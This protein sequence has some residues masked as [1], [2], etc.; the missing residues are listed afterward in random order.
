MDSL[1]IY[2]NTLKDQNLKIEIEMNRRIAKGAKSFRFVQH[3]ELPS[4]TIYLG[5]NNYLALNQHPKI[6]QAIMDAYFTQDNTLSSPTLVNDPNH[7]QI[8]FEEKLAKF[9]GCESLAL[10]QSGWGAN[11]GLLKH[12][13]SLK[14]GP[15]Y[16]DRSA[17][18]SLY[19]GVISGK[20]ELARFKHNDMEDLERLIKKRGA[21]IIVV[22]AMYSTDG[23]LCPLAELV[24]IAEKYGCTTV[25]DEAHSFGAYGPNGE[26]YVAELGL[27]GKVDYITASFGK[28]FAARGG[29]VASRE[30]NITFFKYTAEPYMFSSKLLPH[31]IAQYEKTLEVI[32]EERWR[33]EK[34]HQHSSLI[35]QKL[36]DVGYALEKNDS[37]IIGLRLGNNVDEIIAFR[38]LLFSQGVFGSTFAYPATPI[39]AP[40]IRLAVRSDLTD[41]EINKIIN[42]SIYVYEEL[43]EA[44]LA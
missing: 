25:V 40:L 10:V 44:V 20:G 18:S 12:L 1:E 24:D 19:E 13:S 6:A 26:G 22:D 32:I 28:C 23:D 8:I 11:Y 30:K 4:H 14:T 9:L 41:A 34:L 37:H 2:E 27:S 15:I 35:R 7:P 5:S 36:A 21:G 3:D 17:H 29:L 33:R 31:E 39:N 43:Q 16:I 38:D 42:A